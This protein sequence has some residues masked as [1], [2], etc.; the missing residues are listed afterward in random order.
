MPISLDTETAAALNQTS[1]VASGAIELPFP[2]PYL[3]VINGDARLKTTGDARYFG[4]WATDA[5]KMA[6]ISLIYGGTESPAGWLREEIV[7]ESNKSLDCYLTR[8]VLCAPIDL[9]KSWFVMA[10]GGSVSRSPDYF[11]G[12]RQHVQA[13]VWLAG[14]S[15]DG[16]ITPW[17]PAVLSAKGFQA[18]N[19]LQS[20]ADWTHQTES[21][22]RKIAPG[23][24][25]WCFYLAIGTFGKERKTKMVGAS[26]AQ[27]PITPIGAY[28]PDHLTEETLESLFVGQE[29][30]SEMVRAKQDAAEWLQAWGTP[31]PKPAGQAAPQAALPPDESDFLDPIPPGEEIPF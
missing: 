23:V 17:G 3:W 21:L 8:S 25:A 13:L 27:S 6:E 26:G 14:K 10:T 30:A 15:A 19:L 18:K 22:R 31:S 12:S 4:G 20:F 16:K 7:A 11:A 9:R 29:I 1:I 24:P 5:E 28:I 2:A